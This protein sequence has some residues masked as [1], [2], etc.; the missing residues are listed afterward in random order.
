MQVRDQCSQKNLDRVS[1][2]TNE[3]LRRIIQDSKG[4]A[5]NAF[6]VDAMGKNAA[7]AAS[8][9]VLVGSRTADSAV[10]VNTPHPLRGSHWLVVYLGTGPSNPTCWKV[11]EARVEGKTI[12]FSYLKSPPSPASKDLHRYYYWVPLNELS[13]KWPR[14][15]RK[16][17]PRN[18]SRSWGPP[19]QR[20]A[21]MPPLV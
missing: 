9:S 18:R 15:E 4:G 21:A 10:T 1:K 5:S 20:E 2:S 19:E 14:I 16:F 12:T 17:E 6:L 11:V 8:V 7:I 3:S 13:P